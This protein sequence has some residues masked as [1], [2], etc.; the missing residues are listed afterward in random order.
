MG[1][2]ARDRSKHT[3]IV[4]VEF[5]GKWGRPT[6]MKEEPSRTRVTLIEN[7]ASHSAVQEPVDVKPD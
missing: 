4:C 5:T 3:I 1:S 7:F 6:A 2:D